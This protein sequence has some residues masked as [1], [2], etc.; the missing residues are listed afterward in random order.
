MWC[1]MRAGSSW[2]GTTVVMLGPGFAL[3]LLGYRSDILL[4]DDPASCWL[5]LG[6]AL[7]CHESFLPRPADTAHARG[8]GQCGRR[9]VHG[10]YGVGGFADFWVHV[11]PLR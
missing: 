6:A 8:R 11:G 3:L 4:A 5:A 7:L 9:Y 2:G 10:S 1:A